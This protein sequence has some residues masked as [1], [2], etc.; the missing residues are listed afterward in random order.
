MTSFERAQETWDNMEPYDFDR[1]YSQYLEDKITNPEIAMKNLKK[2]LFTPSSVMD[3]VQVWES[4]KCVSEALDLNEMIEGE[5]PEDNFNAVS[6][7]IYTKHV[8]KQESEYKDLIKRMQIHLISIK[9][10]LYGQE[11]INVFAIQSAIQ[12][13]DYICSGYN[14]EPKKLNIV[15]KG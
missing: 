11:E 12:N 6:K 8:Q 7:Q 2:Y 4:L 14:V 10:A 9:E 5:C 3:S 13:L 15:R 1:N